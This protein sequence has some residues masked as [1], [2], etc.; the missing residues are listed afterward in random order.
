MY[1]IK[2]FT[3]ADLKEKNAICPSTI[4]DGYTYVVTRYSVDAT[5][6]SLIPDVYK[7]TDIA[8]FGSEA[9]AEAYC[10]AAYERYLDISSDIQYFYKVRCVE[11]Y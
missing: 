6:D 10:V 3:I 4:V 11:V 7:Q 1:T 2:K 8:A 5:D 9:D